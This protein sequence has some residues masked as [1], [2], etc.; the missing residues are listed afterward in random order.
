MGAGAPPRR[1]L[2]LRLSAERGW[3]NPPRAI[4]SM[5]TGG[6]IVR[7]SGVAGE[8]GDRGERGVYVSASMY[9]VVAPLTEMISRS[10]DR[11]ELPGR[12]LGEADADAVRE[13]CDRCER[14]ETDRGAGDGTR[15]PG[16]EPAT[17]A[18]PDVV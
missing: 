17:E 12:W 4:E 9:E 2:R 15:D 16:A 1:L 6:D 11:P 7:E 18:A 5:W 13:M 3:A 10:S 8:A 14:L